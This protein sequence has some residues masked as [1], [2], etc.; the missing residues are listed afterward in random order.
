MIGHKSSLAPLKALLREMDVTSFK[1]TEFCQGNTTR[2]GLAWTYCDIDLRKVPQ[3][4]LAASKQLKAK[5][6]L[7]FEFHADTNDLIEMTNK[8][9]AIFNELQ[10]NLNFFDKFNFFN[11]LNF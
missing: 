5:P 11:N 3:L 6:P 1:H 2:W 9:T 10:V 8:L 4:T 7:Y